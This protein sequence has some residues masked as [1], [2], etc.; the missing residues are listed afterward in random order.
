MIRIEVLG[1]G[2]P[3]CQAT[4]TNAQAALSQLG[5]QAELVK[6]YDISEITARGVMMTPALAVDGEVRIAGKVP[7]VDEIKGLLGS[8]E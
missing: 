4:M 6:V 1:T 2:C 7:T 3:S 8:K 5:I